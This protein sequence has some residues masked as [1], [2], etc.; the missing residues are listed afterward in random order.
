MTFKRG[1]AEQ[2]ADISLATMLY[3]LRLLGGSVDIE[4]APG[5]HRTF[6][7]PDTHFSSRSVAGIKSETSCPDP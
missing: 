6:G 1:G 5:E 7:R 3:R 2:D 4:R